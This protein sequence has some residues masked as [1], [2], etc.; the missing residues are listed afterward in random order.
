M[1]RQLNILGS[2]GLDRLIQ[3]Q[4]AVIVKFTADWCGPCKTLKTHLD[5]EVSKGNGW[6]VA[7]VNVDESENKE[8]CEKHVLQGV[9]Q[10]H[11]YI[12]GKEVDRLNL[13]KLKE[14]VQKASAKY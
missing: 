8:I 13:E 6:I 2:A 10:L 4:K 9:P 7:V 12:D 1:S 14:F 3:K 5:Q 11:L